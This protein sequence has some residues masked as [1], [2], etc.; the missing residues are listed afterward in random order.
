MA[1]VLVLPD[2]HLPCMHPKLVSHAKMVQRKYKTS[3]TVC[4][5]DV[6]HHNAI[7]FYDRAPSDPN[8]V[9]ELE[10]ATQQLKSLVKAFP[11][12]LVCYGNHDRRVQRKASAAG[13][14]DAYL[15]SMNE[16]YGMPDSWEWDTTFEIDNVVYCHGDRMGGGTNPAFTQAKKSLKSYVCG[17]FHTVMGMNYFRAGHEYRFGMH[18]GCG[19]DPSH[20]LHQYH[21]KYTHMECVSVAVVIDGVPYLEPLAY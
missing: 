16:V 6:F 13:I 10:Q 21:P 1:K 8:A 18:L 7:S 12:M 17:H 4:L 19:I 15:K 20:T 3:T 2:P 14:P 9:Q 11:S 5:G